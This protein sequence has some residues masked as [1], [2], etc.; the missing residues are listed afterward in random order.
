MELPKYEDLIK[1]ENEELL[2]WYR[3][4]STGWVKVGEKKYFMPST[5]KEEGKN[6]FDYKTRPD[7]TWIVTHP[8]SG[9]TWTQEMVW[10]IRNDLDYKT[11]MDKLLVKR[12]PFFE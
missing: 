6:V 10:L 3:G 11:A 2:K 1:E 7:D 9:T 8:R 5:W 4:L 12:F